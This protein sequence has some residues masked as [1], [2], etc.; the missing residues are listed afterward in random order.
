MS[1]AT[2]SPSARE[3]GDLEAHVDAVSQA[4]QA[5]ALLLVRER[6]ALIARARP[7]VLDAIAVDKQSAV[8]GVGL[9]YGVLRADLERF[10]RDGAGSADS[11]TELKREHPHLSPRVDRLVRLTRDC[12]RANQ[13][14]GV[15]VNARLNGT[16][17]ALQSLRDA[18]IEAT[19]PA[20]Y[21][22]VGGAGAL[23]VAGD[24]FTVRA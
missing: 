11:V 13:E 16:R 4:L 7:D 14:N 19:A 1:A 18:G 12:Q 9:L 6:E 5:L 24:R 22:P 20:T 17:G 21:G 2:A 23:T 15:L 8:A 3:A 10:G